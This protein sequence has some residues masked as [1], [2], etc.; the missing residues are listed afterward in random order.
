MNKKILEHFGME[1]QRAKLAEE[2][3]EYLLD[4]VD[5]EIADIYNIA[6]QL[7]DNS[8]V[9][10]QIAIAKQKRTIDRIKSGYYRR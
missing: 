5:E 2:C 10:Q 3:S 6:K 1:N 7:H 9:I 4:M 8:A